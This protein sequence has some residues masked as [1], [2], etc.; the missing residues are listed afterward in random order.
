MANA[1]KDQQTHGGEHG[2][3][4]SHGIGRYLAVW[5]ALCGFT[6]LTVV[7]GHR[8]LGAVNLPL[9]L[10]I[11]TIKATLLAPAPEGVNGSPRA[12]RDRRRSNLWPE[13]N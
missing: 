2:G 11:A 13:T 5:I 4:H 12:H 6:V 8:D 3:E 10:T 1:T 9:A 7:T